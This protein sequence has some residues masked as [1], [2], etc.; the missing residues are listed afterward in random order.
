MS[1]EIAQVGIGI[2]ANNRT[3]AG[4]K[5]AERRLSQVA[6]R[7]SSA[8][9][10]SNN[11][12][13]RSIRRATSSMVASFSK[14]EQATSKAFGSRSVTATL[15]TKIGAI[16]SAASAMGDGFAGAAAETEGLSAG[17]G[18]VGAAAA[19]TAG[20]LLSAAFAGYKLADNWAKGAAQIGRTADIIG[21]STRTLQEF[22][23][24][25][26]R[27]GVDKGTAQ[28]ALGNLSQTL[29]DARYG[30]NPGAQ[31]A[32]SRL[33]V[34]IK[35]NRDGTV[36]VD[37]MLPAIAGAIAR[38][39][40]SGRRTAASLLGIPLAALPAFSQGGRS[41]GA[42]MADAAKSAPFATP[43]DIK[44]AQ[45]F[46]RKEVML[47]QLGD[48]AL[49]VAGRSAAS[50]GEPVLDALLKAGAEVNSGGSLVS[51]A[52]KLIG[53]AAAGIGKAAEKMERAAGNILVWGDKADTPQIGDTSLYNRIET[54]GER[55]RQD[56]VSPRG[57]VGVMQLLPSTA[58]AVA[59]HFGIPFDEGRFKVDP[60]YNRMLGQRYIDM[61]AQR[62]GGDEV[63][64]AAAYNAGEG[65]ADQWRKRFG[66]PRGNSAADAAF[67]DKIPFKET[68]DYVH[69]VVIDFRNAPKGTTA[70]AHSPGGAIS[71]TTAG[72]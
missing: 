15:A 55:S 64:I 19:A 1:N 60:R 53:D 26:E 41:L 44:N 35:L 40:S 5:A 14:V 46:A 3:E 43:D 59:D 47:G 27:V 25:A 24:A 4:S 70:T 2:V 18:A 57:A 16:R 69:R 7:T 58:R 49:S 13:E 23:A 62:Y 22:S 63:L 21:V 66:D 37:A 33:G 71:Q 48:K 56:Q 30:R 38:Q 12:N 31:A 20:V 11:D 45:R 34:G 39:N 8:I 68:R 42:D 36:N 29:N 10:R 61:L 50:M 65:R 17:I 9:D 54:L 52:G 72:H 67:A 32:L 28:G 51:K 6:R